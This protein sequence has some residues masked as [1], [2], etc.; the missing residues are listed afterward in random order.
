MR[1]VIFTNSYKPTTSGVV[2]SVNV[3]RQGLIEAGHSVY[4][5]TPMREDYED[6][7]HHI[8]RFPALELPD[9]LDL[10]LVIPLKTPMSPTIRGIKPDLIHSQHPFVMGGLASAFARDLKLPLV[11]TFHTRYDEYV[12]RYV[13][14]AP[15]LAGWM[16]EEIVGRYMEKCTSIIAPTPSIR[17][18]IWRDYGSSVPVTVVPTPV[19]LSAYHDLEPGR[20][21]AT[22]HLKD[23]EVLLYVGRLVGEKNL[24]F[25]LRAFARIAPQ[26]PQAR[27]LMV[28]DGTH[29]R[30]LEQMAHKLD[31]GSRVVF[32]GFIPLAEVPHYAA[33]ADLFVFSS[34]TDTQGLVLIEAMAA[35]TPVVAVEAPGPAD[36]LADGGGMLVPLQE[37]TFAE[38]VLELL[39]DDSRRR[40]LGEEATRVAQGYSIP[41]ATQ[42]L[43][44][45]YEA[46]VTAGPSAHK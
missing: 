36:V 46:A 9:R 14:I 3:F 7:E 28:G 39:T 22:L 24:D 17:D 44:E 16:A 25:L 43:L 15:R 42:R 12:Q 10:S 20:V 27:L 32:T 31:L 29:K 40:A 30:S 41:G 11:F 4:I 18:L 38:A 8:F 26:R 33:A 19:D 21:R 1:I 45:V 23:A 35:G 37:E 34:T 13:P 2:R 5:I 6:E